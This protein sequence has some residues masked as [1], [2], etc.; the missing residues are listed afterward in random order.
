MRFDFSYS[1]TCRAPLIYINI[2]HE[3]GRCNQIWARLS[4]C[5]DVHTSGPLP[6]R[7]TALACHTNSRCRPLKE[8]S[9]IFRNKE[10]NSSGSIHLSHKAGAAQ[11]T[12]L[13]PHSRKWNFALWS[14]PAP[15]SSPHSGVTKWRSASQGSGSIRNYVMLFLWAHYIW[16]LFILAEVSAS[17]HLPLAKVKKTESELEVCVFCHDCWWL[18]SEKL[19]LKAAC[20]VG[21]KDWGWFLCCTDSPVQSSG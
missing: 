15:R 19:L 1:A 3:W 17:P 4:L 12:G 10:K 18:G 8:M 13:L 9:D 2:M 7:G 20:S 11:C 16:V 14:M 6:V 5:R 21:W